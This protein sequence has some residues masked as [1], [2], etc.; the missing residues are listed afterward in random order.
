MISSLCKNADFSSDTIKA[1]VKYG[2]LKTNQIL[3]NI[4]ISYSPYYLA[5]QEK[6]IG[7]SIES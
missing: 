7:Q 1:P 3:K 5:L 4:K 6:I 2:K